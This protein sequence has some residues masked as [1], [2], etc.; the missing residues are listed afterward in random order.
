MSKHK[1]LM[2][3]NNC[4]FD[5]PDGSSKCNQCGTTLFEAGGFFSSSVYNYVSRWQ[6]FYCNAKNLSVNKKCHSCFKLQS[7]GIIDKMLGK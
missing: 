4:A 7:P 1:Y 3:C 2:T 5:N 6:C